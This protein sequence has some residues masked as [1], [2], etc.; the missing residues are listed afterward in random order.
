MN[1]IHFAI[2]FLLY[3]GTRTGDDDCKGDVTLVN[4]QRRFATHVSR[5]NLQTWYTFKSLSKTSNALQHCKYRKESSATG[6]YTG[7]IFRATSYHCKCL[8]SLSGRRSGEMLDFLFSS[9]AIE[10]LERARV[11]LRAA[12]PLARSS[13]SNY[14][15]RERKGTACSLGRCPF[16]QTF[17]Q[18]TLTVVRRLTSIF[19]KCLWKLEPGV[20]E[21]KRYVARVGWNFSQNPNWNGNKFDWN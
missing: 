2:A 15:G 13:L 16:D 1:Q 12:V 4:L 17:A 14:C 21:P 11:I 20:L 7:T 9:T 3:W 18:S 19:K 5:T 10:R 8:G 6:C